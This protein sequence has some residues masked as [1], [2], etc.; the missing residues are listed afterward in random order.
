M[1]V[2]A[3]CACVRVCVRVCVQ[4]G[5]VD[6]DAAAALLQAA[7]ASVGAAR[8][9]VRCRDRAWARRIAATLSEV[10]SAVDA[11]VAFR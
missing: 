8:E 11:L 10:E 3:S 5:L 6:D 4:A 7:Y 9:A 2:T 1:R